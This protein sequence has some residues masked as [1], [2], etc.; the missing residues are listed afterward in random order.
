MSDEITSNAEVLVTICVTSARN[1]EVEKKRFNDVFFPAQTGPTHH[2]QEVFKSEILSSSATHI[3]N[4]SE[5]CGAKG[6]TAA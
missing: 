6:F 4:G 1:M 5:R 3:V 2:G